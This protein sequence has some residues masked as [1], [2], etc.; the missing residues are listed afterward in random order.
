MSC[1]F[2]SV[3]SNAF[4]SAPV[5]SMST[6]SRVECA[7]MFATSSKVNELV[8]SFFGSTPKSLSTPSRRRSATR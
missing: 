6:P 2:F 8:A 3:N 4:E 5:V 7:T 1:T